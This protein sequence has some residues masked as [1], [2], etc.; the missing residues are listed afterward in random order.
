V[1]ELHV[2][3]FDGTLFRSPDKPA[4]WPKGTFW[5][6]HP[7]SLDEPCVP[8]KPGND[9]W[10]AA[11][12]A[13]AKKSIA[14]PDVLAIL[15]TG[16]IDNSFARYRVPELL[17][18]KGLN[19]DQVHLS[20]STDTAAFKMNVMRPLIKRHDIEVVQIWEDHTSNLNK[21][22][23]MVE[24]MG[25]KGVPHVVNQ[26]RKPAKCPEFDTRAA[27]LAE[28]FANAVLVSSPEYRRERK[29]AEGVTRLAERWV[30]AAGT[31]ADITDNIK[32][33]IFTYNRMLH[34]IEGGQEA[35]WE[36]THNGLRRMSNK[37]WIQLMDYGYKI[38]NG[39]L[40]TRSIPAR[41]VKGMEM[42]LR[43]FANSRRMPKDVYKWWATNHKRLMLIIAGAAQW[44]EKQEGG[45][46]LFTIG[47]FKVHNTI[48]E[49]GPGL[50]TFKKA[51]LAAAKMAQGNPV[52]GFNKVLYGEVYLV[53]QIAKAH[54][55]AWYNSAED[56]LYI[57]MNNKRW[58]MDGAQTIV[59]ELGHR[60]WRKFANKAAKSQWESHHIDVTYKKVELPMPQVGDK[61]PLRLRGAPRGWRPTVARMDKTNYFYERPDGTEGKILSFNIWKVVRQNEGAALRFPT[62]YAS[63]SEEEHF[64]ES[65]KLQAAGV[66][67]AEHA[68]AFKTIWA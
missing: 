56:I 48:G 19:F 23:K 24:D 15:V 20:S 25:V 8:L 27:R 3:D 11:T 30:Q 5:I 18:Q 28:K 51:L 14:N 42:A 6:K 68:E 62:A 59:H 64:C 46:D 33:F 43:L 57:R 41:Q 40:S 45:D 61:L 58:G 29:M 34:T 2:Y 39:L 37:P 36:G 66:L 16:R 52:P 53:G 13:D 21:F 12:V 54:H 55:A 60:Y 22:I 67:P 65:L 17:K 26:P 44:P 7:A 35:G 63:T 10:I 38:A 32:I 9:F 31:A 47:P 49:S 4:W 1:P 50:E